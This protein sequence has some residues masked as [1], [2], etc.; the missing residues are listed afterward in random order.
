MS[1]TP[2]HHEWPTSL[3]QVPSEGPGQRTPKLRASC[4]SCAA[5]KVKCGKERPRCARC[6]SCG[7][8]CVY[9]PSRK[10]GKPGRHRRRNPDAG[11]SARGIARGVSSTLNQDQYPELQLAFKGLMQD[12]GHGGWNP[13]GVSNMATDDHLG[14][15][16]F[17]FL[18]DGSMLIPDHSA[19]RRIESLDTD[20]SSIKHAFTKCDEP[21]GGL[22]ISPVSMDFQDFK[23]FINT[24]AIQPMDT[25]LDRSHILEPTQG[26]ADCL[27]S[28]RLA[29]GKGTYTHC[30]YNLAYTTLESLH[31]RSLESGSAS[32]T[33]TTSNA[34]PVSPTSSPF[35]NFF[36]SAAPSGQ[37]LDS[38]LRNNKTAISNVLQLLTCPCAHDPHLAMLYASIASKILIWYQIAGGIKPSYS[39][40]P[41]T[42]SASTPSS[43]GSMT[44]CMGSSMPTSRSGL[45]SSTPAAITLTPITIG[46][47]S[48]DEDDQ[49]PLRRQ[50]LL[51][52]LRKAGQLIDTLATWH[53]EDW[54]EVDHLYGTLGAWLKSELLRTIREVKEGLGGVTDR[55][56]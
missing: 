41:T 31:F 1:S 16:A 2:P 14:G 27:F 13:N 26:H 35:S 51:S 49:E 5:A 20:S 46:A 42:H 6:V 53:L 34:S 43:I 39:T 10:H 28:Q 3:S 30:C 32:T 29:G 47:F 55:G 52:E 4:D 37:T 45:G 23:T 18:D 50:F 48:L 56:A 22:C 21:Q 12:A 7:T 54:N 40:P 9:G 44:G 25:S 36:H 17:S 19:A 33:S 24:D 15:S 11:N 8:T 38:V